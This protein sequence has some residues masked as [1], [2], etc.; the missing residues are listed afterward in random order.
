MGLGVIEEKNLNDII[1]YALDYPKMVLS[2]VKT[3]S[4]ASNL[5]DFALG[6][7]IGYICG[8][9]YDGF[10]HRNKRYL[11]LEESSEFHEIILKRT[12]ELRL[13]I[14]TYLQIK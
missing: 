5:E 1:S 13:K 10:L 11:D 14:K 9:F 8:I 6:I 7:Y 2:E 3:L 4:T 12:P